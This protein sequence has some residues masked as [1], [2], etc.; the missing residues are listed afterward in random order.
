VDGSLLEAWASV[1]SF[2]PKNQKSSPPPDDPEI[3]RWI[4]AARSARTKR[5]SRKAIQKR[6]WRA[7]ARA[8]RQ[9]ELQRES[10]VENRNGLIVDSRV[11]EATGTAERYA[12][13]EMLQEIQEAGA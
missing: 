4:I 5:T 7:K 3:L 12:A 10:A 6:N 1:K 2:Q 11:W 8:R 13:P 9:V